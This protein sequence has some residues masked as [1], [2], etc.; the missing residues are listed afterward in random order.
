VRGA[1]SD[2]RPYRDPIEP[3]GA[4]A[5]DPVVQQG[6]TIARQNCFR[7]HSRSGEGGQ[8][9]KLLWRDLAHEALMNPTR[10][11]AYVRHPKNI[12]PQSQ[13]AASP[14]YDDAT[15]NALRRYFASFQETS[16]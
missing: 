16:R 3:Q 6:Y 12:I 11:D 4:A 10:F 13:M 15:L 1:I 14:Q 2:G 5:N 7:C 8:K 9:S